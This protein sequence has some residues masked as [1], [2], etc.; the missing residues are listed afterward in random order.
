M[1]AAVG[2]SPRI[3]R[4]SSEA[5]QARPHRRPGREP[6]RDGK[7]PDRLHE[8]ERDHDRDGEAGERGQD[9]L[10]RVVGRIQAARRQVS[11]RIERHGDG[12]GRQDRGRD[13]DVLGVEGAAAEQD[14]DQER[15]D[16][17]QADGGQRPR[18][19]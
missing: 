15:A 13:P 2:A 14:L 16:H 5:L 8:R 4:A 9:R 3:R 7:D 12:E 6:E 18:A 11:E 17:E 19:P 1:A 10:H